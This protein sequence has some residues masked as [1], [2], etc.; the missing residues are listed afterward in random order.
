M[1][2]SVGQCCWVT[3]DT[4]ANAMLPPRILQAN[5]IGE[6]DRVVHTFVNHEEKF[7]KQEFRA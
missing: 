1:L 3:T 2:D 7:I 4:Y 6:D 5:Y